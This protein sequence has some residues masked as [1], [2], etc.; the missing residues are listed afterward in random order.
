MSTS[1]A[2]RI[3]PNRILN[4]TQNGIKRITLSA[5]KVA[6]NIPEVKPLRT[7][8]K[9]K[10]FFLTVTHADRGML[11]DHAHQVIATAAILA[12]KKLPLWR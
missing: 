4:T 5:P 2:K 11:D 10:N 3:N 9:P 1:K 7:P 8:T 6:E 12:D